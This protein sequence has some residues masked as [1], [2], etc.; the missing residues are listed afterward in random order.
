MPNRERS[1]HEPVFF[2]YAVHIFSDF[3]HQ[4]LKNS[5]HFNGVS[6]LYTN[7]GEFGCFYHALVSFDIGTYY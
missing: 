4:N 1:L 7:P 3:W 2:C 6:D 5:T